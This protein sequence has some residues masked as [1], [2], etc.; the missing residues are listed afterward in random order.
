MAQCGRC[1]RE[2]DSLYGFRT[3]A[4][5]RRE[6]ICGACHEEAKE[7]RGLTPAEIIQDNARWD[8][9]FRGF[10]D[11]DYYKPSP[12]TMRSSFGAFASQ[13]EMLCR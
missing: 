12:P 1:G 13:M 6:K 11:P 8:R 10:I 5:A 4:Y 7:N 9:I 2:S 3:D